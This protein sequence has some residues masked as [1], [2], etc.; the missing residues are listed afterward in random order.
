MLKDARQECTAELRD[1]VFDQREPIRC[2]SCMRWG[3][4]VSR[5]YFRMS[6]S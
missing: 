5:C 3:G 4:G 2:D 6:W 1:F